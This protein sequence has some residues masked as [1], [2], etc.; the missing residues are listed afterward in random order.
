MVLADSHLMLVALPWLAPVVE[1]EGV[2]V[3]DTAM[4]KMEIV[5][6]TVYRGR[7]VLSGSFG[8]LVLCRLVEMLGAETVGVTTCTGSPLTQ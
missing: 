3:G 6:S 4:F 1:A 8:M 5:V 2:E 7:A